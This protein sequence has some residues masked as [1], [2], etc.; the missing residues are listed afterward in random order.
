MHCRMFHYRGR[1]RHLVACDQL[2]FQSNLLDVVTF[3]G[4]A[5]L[6]PITL[7]KAKL[8]ASIQLLKGGKMKNR[9]YFSGYRKIS[10]NVKIIHS[11]IAFTITL[12]NHN[13]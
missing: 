11:H 9:F 5:Q 2:L 3:D 6:T 12:Y 1:P 10:I 7:I 13:L 8:I 4:Y